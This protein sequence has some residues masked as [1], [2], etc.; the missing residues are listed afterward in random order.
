[1][2][3]RGFTLVELLVVIAII[4]VLVALLLPA[5]QAAREAAR[6]RACTNNVKQMAL[7]FLNHESTQG[8]LP[9]GG[10]GFYWVGDPDRGYG[11]NQP[12]GWCYNILAYIEQANLRNNGKGITDPVQKEA[13]LKVTITSLLPIY[14]CPSKRPL[15]AYPMA[16]RTPNY[17]AHNLQSCS[18]DTACAVA[19]N[20]YRVNAGNTSPND[21]AG[22]TLTESPSTYFTTDAFNN[23]SGVCFRQSTIRIKD[24][25]DGT[26]NTAMIGEKGLDPRYYE[27]GEGS[28]DDQCV[29][30][31]HDRDNVGYTGSTDQLVPRL[32]AE[33]VNG[34]NGADYRFGSTHPGGL[35]MA[36][37]DGSVQE[38]SYDIDP[39]VF[40]LSGGRD[41]GR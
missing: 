31:G 12:G 4:G 30:T 38:V 22:P 6:K 19:R 7:G 29:F 20:D 8:H 41:D 21:Q 37:S 14:N 10:W 1:M 32:D 27:S 11:K 24:I 18:S 5:I 13:A 23:Q 26:S 2:R 17:I 35:N 33:G 25:L 40:R 15:R 39:E 3:R 9:T 16:P 36:Y 28:L 34:G